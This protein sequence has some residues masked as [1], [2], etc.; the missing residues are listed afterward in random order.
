MDELINNFKLLNLIDNKSK[1]QKIIKI[2]VENIQYKE[3]DLEKYNINHNGK[4]GHWLESKFGIKHNNKNESDLYGFEIKKES[5]KITF[6]DFSAS[7][8]IF[9]KT[10][11]KINK[12]NNWINEELI[13]R[14]EFMKYFGSYN[15]KKDRYSWSGKVI[16]KCNIY[17]DVGQILKITNK[18]N[19]YI[20]Y[21]YSKDKRENK[22]E[23]VPNF[24]QKEN[25][26]IVYWSCDKMKKHINNKFNNNGFIICHKNED[27]KYHKLSFGKRFD[28]IEFISYM[29]KR[30]IIFDSGMYE[31]NNRNY[32]QFRSNKHFWLNL[33]IEEYE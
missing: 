27:N 32:S 9:S 24:L 26:Y 6:G 13:T 31:G 20:K 12:K 29:K 18:N 14:L 7:E 16:P 19:I 22:N 4:E 10:K 21:S 17:N 11:T 2:F 8:Y 15:N 1:K 25:L 23:I 3:I 5:N 30:I 28:Y 33:I